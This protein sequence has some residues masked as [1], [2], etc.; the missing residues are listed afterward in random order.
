[1]KKL[2]LCLA[3]STLLFAA[4][5]KK[6]TVVS[7]VAH[8]VAASQPKPWVFFDLGDTVV[9]VKVEVEQKYLPGAQA[10][11]KSLREAGFGV[12]LIVNIPESWGRTYVAKFSEL[13]RFMDGLRQKK[14]ADSKWASEIEF[15][16]NDYDEVLLPKSNL[17]RKPS[18][19]MFKRARDIAAPCPVLYQGENEKELAAAQSVGLVTHLV[20][21]QEGFWAQN[22][23]AYLRE[24]AG[25]SENVLAA[26]G[27]N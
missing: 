25:V 27:L 16:W 7:E 2:V 13:V 22:P 11:L 20:G 5:E 4:C 19:E 6:M 14:Y 23:K 26:C 21:K 17:E 15:D 9:E 1:M 12:G 24:K 18:P 10:Y 8:R 3:F